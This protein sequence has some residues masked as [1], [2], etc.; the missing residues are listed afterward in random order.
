MH[1][2]TLYAWTVTASTAAAVTALTV[3][4]AQAAVI[5]DADAAQGV[6]VFVTTLCD[7]PASVTTG[8]W[9]DGHGS[10]FKF[11]KPI[12]VARCEAHSVRT[13]AGEYTFRDNSTYWFGWDSMTKTGN[14]QTVFQWKSNGTNDQNSQNY[15]V[16]MKVED[17][18]LKAWY[19]E[20]GENW[21]SIGTTPWT[22]GEWHSI[23]L[24]ITTD[25][26][27]AGTLS[28]YKDG[29]E[30]ASRTGARTWDDLGNKPR[31]GTYFGTDTSTASINWVAGLAMG[32]SRADVD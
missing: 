32:T 13:S 23:Q 18:R 26:A 17:G 31:W 29:T 10:F 11:N 2:R 21:V 15:P 5:W 27:G 1:R 8:N 3:A 14:A 25:S 28:V 6:G 16:L 19:V 12:G 20:P 30:F 4:P 7:S 9:N 22:A 24:G